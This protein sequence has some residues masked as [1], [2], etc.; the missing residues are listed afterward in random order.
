MALGTPTS[1]SENLPARFR[2]ARRCSR[3]LTD[4]AKVSDDRPGFVLA[5]IIRR[6]LRTGNA[7]GDGL[8]NLAIGVAMHPAPS[9]QI[10]AFAASARVRSMTQSA[11]VSEERVPFLDRLRVPLQRILHNDFLLLCTEEAL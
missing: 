9:G 11:I 5:E 4:A 10:R 2:I 3:S 7:F 1:A 8:K 6:H